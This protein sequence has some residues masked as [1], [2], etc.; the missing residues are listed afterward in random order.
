MSRLNELVAKGDGLAVIE[1]GL[2]LGGGNLI[3]FGINSNTSANGFIKCLYKR[4]ELPNMAAAQAAF[5]GK[6]ANDKGGQLVVNSNSP[7]PKRFLKAGAGVP[8]AS[9]NLD[10]SPIRTKL[11]DMTGQGLDEGDDSDEDAMDEEDVYQP[12]RYE[13]IALNPFKDLYKQSPL[14]QMS[15]EFGPSC[16]PLSTV[17]MILNY[18][19]NHLLHYIH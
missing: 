16:I 6:D 10:A 12:K 7:N 5:L 19:G 1:Q 3:N 13:Y 8:A 17:G 14:I 11:K 2:T 15:F 4:R 9:A 18:T